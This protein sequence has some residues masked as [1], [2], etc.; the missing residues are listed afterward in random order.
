MDNKSLAFFSLIIAV[1]FNA[2]GDFGAY[3]RVR[4]LESTIERLEEQILELR[5]R[6]E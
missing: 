1:T 3:S 5:K 4:R 2:L 6:G